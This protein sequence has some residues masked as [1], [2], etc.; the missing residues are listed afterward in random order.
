MNEVQPINKFH[1]SIWVQGFA[2]ENSQISR[3]AS[4]LSQVQTYGLCKG[5]TVRLD[6]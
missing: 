4:L 1:S 6:L 3:E 2:W 5:I